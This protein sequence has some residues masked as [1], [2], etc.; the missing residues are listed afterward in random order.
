[1]SGREKLAVAATFPVDPPRGGGQVRIF[2]LYRELAR[3]Y[4]VELVTLGLPG[5]SANRKEIAPGVWETRVP[6]SVEHAELE[7]RLESEA[8][9]LVTDV[10]MTRYYRHSVDYLDALRKAS[11]GARAVVASHPYTLPAIREVSDAPLWY[12]AHNVEASL[13]AGI[14][15]GTDRA[16]ELLADVESVERACCEQAEAIWA[17]SV[18]DRAELVSRY[19]LAADRVL[20]VANGVALDELNYVAIPKRRQIKRRLG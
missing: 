9:A 10:A 12:D 3:V 13:K 15:V 6:K 7:W 17:C 16:R 14:L 18:E 4:D 19:R 1:V 5:T 11:R 20:V 8:G 2:H